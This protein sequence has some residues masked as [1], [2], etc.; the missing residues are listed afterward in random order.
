MMAKPITLSMDE[1]C[2]VRCEVDGIYHQFFLRRVCDPGLPLQ[3][4]RGTPKE[5]C[6]GE[7]AVPFEGHLR[8]LEGAFDRV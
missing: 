4:L 6:Y 1:L 5:R 3:L 8:F 7:S 2:R